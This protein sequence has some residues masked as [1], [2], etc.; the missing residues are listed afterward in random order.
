[1][2]AR[3][4]D[5]HQ[6]HGKRAESSKSSTPLRDYFGAVKVRP[7]LVAIPLAVAAV[8]FVREAIELDDSLLIGLALWGVFLVC[9]VVSSVVLTGL[10]CALLSARRRRLARPTRTTVSWSLLIACLVL[11]PVHASWNTVEGPNSAGGLTSAADAALLRV[12]WIDHPGL[13]YSETCCG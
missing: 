9:C 2:A 3:G 7:R 12:D 11:F 1:M 6:V 4:T 8:I 13:P 5:R 10:A